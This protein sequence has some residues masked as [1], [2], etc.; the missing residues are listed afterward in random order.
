MNREEL[1]RNQIQIRSTPSDYP[2][3]MRINRDYCIGYQLNITCDKRPWNIMS[4]TTYIKKDIAS[5]IL[6]QNVIVNEKTLICPD[7]LF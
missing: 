5:C 4:I 6:F 7:W 2:K 1:F 3:M